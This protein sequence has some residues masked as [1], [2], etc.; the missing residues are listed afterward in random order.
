MVAHFALSAAANAQPTACASRS[1]GDGARIEEASFVPLGG[2]EQFVTIRGD[3]RS[4]PVL[5]HIHGGPGWAFA[6]FTAEFAPY[7]ADFTVVQWDQRGSGCTFGRHGEATPE[8]TLDRLASDGIEL[9]GH[10][11]SRLGGPKIIVLGHSFGSIVAIEMVRRAPE[12]F[13]LYVGTAQF[14]S[15]AGA[16]EAQLA[17]LHR[18][19]A[20]DPVLTSELVALAALDSQSLQRFGGV[21]RILQ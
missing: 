2:I 7:E 15:F 9:A 12:Q 16:V 14:A 11:R 13:V 21:N 1:S 18:L 20:D 3:D 8:L 4:N 6:A 10:L 19:A 17:H 5:L